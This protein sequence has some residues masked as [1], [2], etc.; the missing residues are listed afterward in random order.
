MSTAVS[1]RAQLGFPT[2]MILLVR[3]PGRGAP[4]TARFGCPCSWSGETFAAGD[5]TTHTDEV[6]SARRHH[7]NC[8][9]ATP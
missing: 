7:D 6:A 5:P 3:S 1:A 4:T 2:R 8:K 9:E